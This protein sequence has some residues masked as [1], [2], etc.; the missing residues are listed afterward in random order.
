[1]DEVYHC[2]ERQVLV[3]GPAGTGKTWTDHMRNVSLCQL[4]PGVRILY[5]RQVRADMGETVL[6]SLEQVLG[7]DSEIVLN[8]PSRD[9]R[10]VYSF[11]NGSEIIIAGLDRPERTYSGEYHQVVLFEAN[12]IPKDSYERLFRTLRGPN[13]LGF[14]Q[15]RVE[16][17]PD[18]ATH[19][20]NRHFVAGPGVA[21]IKTTHRDNPY[22][23]N[24][25]AGRFTPEGEEYMAT[26]RCLTG[27]RRARLL[28]GQWVGAEGMIYDEWDPSV[29]V[30]DQMPHGWQKW[31]RV[32]AIDLGYEEPFVCL[33]A[34]VSPDRRIYV[35]REYV[36]CRKICEAHAQEI[37]RL[38]GSERYEATVCDHYAEDRA[39]LS[40]HGVETE[41]AIKPRAGVQDTTAWP[42][43][44]E[45]VKRRLRDQK[46]YVLRGALAAGGG[47]E[48]ILQRA[49]K[50]CGLLEELPGYA[51]E[52]PKP[53]KPSKERPRSVNDHSCDALRYLVW[54]V[55][56]RPELG[57][58]R[59]APAM[60]TAELPIYEEDPADEVGDWSLG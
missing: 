37:K 6:K 42:A 4:R 48:E 39:T 52:P 12:D 34:A 54:C 60:S 10:K 51:W 55:E 59:P 50:P 7:E 14:F 31:P 16:V 1:M 3:E 35:Y 56:S 29:H 58:A 57:T 46:L 20:I 25:A 21:R 11:P 47:P 41:P 17:N 18:A 9:T 44:F 32:R 26:L 49:S 22:L 23:W 30:I 8:G 5:A 36:R 27:H 33:W 38:S 43:A 15:I 45:P 53:D 28:E 13:P 2:N 24:E 19:W 40:V